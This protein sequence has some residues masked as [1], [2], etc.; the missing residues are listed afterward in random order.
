MNLTF[1]SSKC[2]YCC[3]ADARKVWNATLGDELHNF[4][5]KHIV[6]CVEFCDDGTRLLTGSN[7]KLLRVYDLSRPDAGQFSLVSVWRFCYRAFHSQITVEAL[8]SVLTF[9]AISRP[10]F[11]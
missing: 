2:A 5:H 7:E 9:K 3:V 8:F 11:N 10:A 1:S 4:P 6:K